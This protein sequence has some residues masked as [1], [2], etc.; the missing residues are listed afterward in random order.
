MFTDLPSFGANGQL[1]PMIFYH[2]SLMREPQYM[3][4]ADGRPL[5]FM[6][7]LGKI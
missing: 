5:Y 3:R 7:T 4:V 6:G 2:A 1:A